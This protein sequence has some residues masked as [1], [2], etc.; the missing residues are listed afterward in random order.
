MENNRITVDNLFTLYSFFE[1]LKRKK[2]KM[3]C[4]FI[5]FEKAFD[6]IWRL[7]LKIAVKSLPKQL[8]NVIGLKFLGLKTTSNQFIEIYE[9]LFILIFDT[10]FVHESWVVGNIIPIYKNKGDSNDPKNIR[11]ITLVKF[12]L[13]GC[14]NSD[15]NSVRLSY[16]HS[17]KVYLFHQNSM[18]HHLIFF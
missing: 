6:K 11:P 14:I 8:T 10:G 5:D 17:E 3:Y 12:R 7:S 15:Y 9:K 16:H 13:F 1:F 4:A 18:E 2:K